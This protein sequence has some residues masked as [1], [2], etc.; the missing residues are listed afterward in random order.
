MPSCRLVLLGLTLGVALAGSAFAQSA[1]DGGSGD[2]P[3]T[4]TAHRAPDSQRQANRLARRLQLNP[5]QAAAIEPILQSRTQQ[6]EQL[7]AD[8]SL[9]PR[10]RHSRMRAMNQDVDSR[11]QA[12]L[13][14]SQRQQ[15][16]QMM[17]QAKLRRQDR[18]DGAANPPPAPDGGE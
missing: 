13:T 1:P 8:A 15:Y 4:A 3:E 16:R 5:Q 7:R 11:L 10:E 14:D 2:M 17:Q 9:T 6:M 12:V 18:K